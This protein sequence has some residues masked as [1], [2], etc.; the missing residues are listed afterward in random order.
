MEPQTYLRKYKIQVILLIAIVVG[1]IGIALTRTDIESKFIRSTLGFISGTSSR[2]SDVTSA[3]TDIEDVVSDEDTTQTGAS[4]NTTVATPRGGEPIGTTLDIPNDIPQANNTFATTNINTATSITLSFVDYKEGSSGSERIFNIT[5]NPSNGVL[6]GT[7]STRTYTPNNGFTGTDTVIWTVSD[8]TYTSTPGSVKIFVK[9]DIYTDGWYTVAANSERSSWVA[10]GVTN[11]TGMLWHTP[12]EAYISQ[13][14][15]IIASDGKLF[16]STAKGVYALDAAT[17]LVSWKFNTE[18][19]VGNSPTVFDDTVYFGGFDKKLHALDVTTGTELL[20]GNW[21]FDGANAGYSAN[22]LV[23]NDSYT[24]NQTVVIIPNRD[25]RVYFVGG[26][27]HPNEGDAIRSINISSPI[28]QTPAYKDGIIY[29]AANDNYAYAYNIDTGIQ[30]WKSDKLRGDGFASYWPVI[31][32][33]LV[34]FTKAHDYLYDDTGSRVS[35]TWN[36][37]EDN[38]G[39]VAPGQMLGTI[40]GSLPWSNG[41]T[42]TE[43]GDTLLE[44]LEENINEAN[45]SPSGHQHKPELRGNMVLDIST[46]IEVKSWDHDNDGF[47]EYFPSI[48]D[49]TGSGNRIPGIVDPAGYMV[50]M[51]NAALCCSDAKGM[52]YG[53]DSDYPY[54]FMM[55]SGTPPRTFFRGN[56]SIDPNGDTMTYSWNFDDGTTSTSTNPNKAYKTVNNVYNVVLTVTDSQG[57]SSQDTQMVKIPYD[58]GENQYPIALFTANAYSGTAPLNVTFNGTTSWDPRSSNTL[59]YAWDFNGDSIVDSTIAAPSY[60]YTSNGTYDVT[61]TVT[62]SGG[63]SDVTRGRIVV[64]SNPGN[65]PPWARINMSL[66]GISWGGAGWHA[67]AEPQMLSGGGNVIYRNL[68]CDRIGDWST[69]YN[70]NN[71][72]TQSGILWDYNNSLQLQSSNSFNPFWQ[73]YPFTS[74]LYNWYQGYEDEYVDIPYDEYNYIATNGIYNNH[75]DQNPIVPYNGR[76]YVHRGNTIIAFGPGGG[77][78]AANPAVEAVDVEIATVANNSDVN[79]KLETEITKILNIYDSLGYTGNRRFLRPGHY[80]MSQWSYGELLGDYFQNPGDTLLTLARAYPHVNPSLQSRLSNYMQDYYTAYFATDTYV[81]V[82]WVE[83]TS[84]EAFPLPTPMQTS[85]DNNA[86]SMRSSSTTSRTA[87]PQRNIYAMY[88]YA[89]LI[90]D[91]VITSTHTVADI[92]NDAR[93]RI[94]YPFSFPSTFTCVNTTTGQ[95]YS[96][97]IPYW[98]YF[99]ESP[100]ELN[101]D[102]AGYYGFRELQILANQTGDAQY[103]AASIQSQLD[104]LTDYKKHTFNR[105]S[106]WIENDRVPGA[107]PCVP[108]ETRNYQKKELDVARNFIW[109]VPEMA[110]FLKGNVEM[111]EAIKEYDIVGSYWMVSRYEGMVGEGA[112]AALYNYESMFKAKAYIEGATASELY[113]FLD[114]PAF[115]TGDLFYIDNLVTVLEDTNTIPGSNSAPVVHAGDDFSAAINQTYLLE[116]VSTDDGLPNYPGNSSFAWSEQSGPGTA[117][118]SNVS[119][120]NTKVVFDQ[121]GTYVLRLT[122]NDTQLTAYDE[123]TVNVNNIPPVSSFTATPTGGLIPLNVD[124]DASDSTDS[125][126]NIASYSWDFGDGF[127][128]TGETVSHTYTVIG[129]FVAKLTV[130]DDDGATHTT[131]IVIAPTGVGYPLAS[132]TADPIVG[133]SP[134]TVSVNGTASYDPNGTINSYQWRWGDGAAAGSGSTNSHVYTIVGTFRL[135]LIVTDNSGL[136]DTTWVY[137]TVNEPGG[138]GNQTPNASFTANPQSGLAPLDV[139]VNATNSIDSDGTIASYSWNW[140]DGTPNGSG[141]TAS[142]QYSNPGNYTIVLTVTDNDGATDNASVAIV[143]T[144]ES[145]QPPNASFTASPTSGTAPLNVNVNG[146]GSTDSDGTIASYSWNWG[147]GSSA[148]S[149]A[150]ASHQYGNEGS[151]TITL[152]V[153]DDDGATDTATTMITVSEEGGGGGGSNMLPTAQAY[154]SSYVPGTNTATFVGTNSFDPD[155]SIVSWEWDFNNNGVYDA[156]GSTVTF[157]TSVAG[158]YIVILRVTDDDGDT[159]TDSVSF[160]RASN[161]DISFYPSSNFTVSDDNN[162]GQKYVQLVNGSAPV[163]LTHYPH[164]GDMEQSGS[165]WTPLPTR[166]NRFEWDFEGD[167]TYDVVYNTPTPADFVQHTYTAVG[168]YTVKL[169]VRSVDGQ[170]EVTD[171]TLYVVSDNDAP[172]ASFT[173]VPAS[174]LFPLDV[175]VNASASTDSDGTIVSYSWNWGDGTP[176]GSGVTAS[177]TYST[178]GNYT[179]TLTVTDNEGGIDTDSEGILVTS[180]NLSPSSS[181]RVNQRL[182]MVPFIV[183]FNATSSVDPDGSIVN[184]TWNFGDG[185]GG[186]GAQTTHTYTSVGS[187]NVSLLVTDDD[188]ATSTSSFNLAT[189]AIVDAS[190][191]RYRWWTLRP[192]YEYTGNILNCGPIETTGGVQ[193]NAGA[194]ELFAKDQGMKLVSTAN[195]TIG[196]LSSVTL[197]RNINESQHIA[198]TI[199]KIDAGERVVSGG[200]VSGVDY[201]TM[202]S[203]EIAAGLPLWYSHFYPVLLNSEKGHYFLNGINYPY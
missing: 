179:I 117:T 127:F 14:T 197:T 126:G 133:T 74:G 138:G 202:N 101:Q 187:Y 87:Y 192:N 16:I 157:T 27:D 155:G 59:T 118:F 131:S 41:N 95:Q 71:L 171:M 137:I 191:A 151:Y 91:G 53:W 143:A 97:N 159:D 42:I 203:G 167:G 140:G 161:G 69:I 76:L 44:C 184:Y 160:T 132:F 183:S 19:P 198:D 73:R 15:Q 83:G 6:S 180:A 29:F 47:N 150:N 195:G 43:F 149:G 94:N 18:S 135:E 105:G 144:S 4:S 145:N 36:V 142:H 162:P 51:T 50:Y 46:G 156:V 122:V 67:M 8:G 30:V 102:W 99:G 165:P 141:V 98:H 130:T 75:G 93:G 13:N 115:I 113:E 199:A 163:T 39:T 112:K 189:C 40:T 125:D 110:D 23:I 114:A 188:G 28:A 124:F 48:M 186:S 100:Y 70:S 80:V 106:W 90:D 24:D 9:N 147:D 7:G 54:H 86:G 1:S 66:T 108:E 177:H 121:Q 32:D 153:T 57:N 201:G 164:S 22:P 79:T 148:G 25:G 154:A 120:P 146:S 78:P 52:I 37:E 31:Y 168:A 190:Q 12:I 85:I 173:A 123:V 175:E 82:G 55:T 152:T 62:D 136:S 103:P 116:G 166:I 3:P 81:D 17:G 158:T 104:I 109:M 65:Q 111:K 68:C 170:A 129:D 107:M 200:T 196:E 193:S 89:Q 174:G 84:R 64:G 11:S 35:C 61:L 88:K 178:P 33:N 34:F 2:D 60:N 77:S 26:K 21:P 56:S 92:Y 45:P 182:G 38:P 5:G 119:D 128:G 194:L 72:P 96:I 169:R 58:P 20:S 172:V 185:T 10:N 181:F 49:G 139:D 63:L 176:N 134:L